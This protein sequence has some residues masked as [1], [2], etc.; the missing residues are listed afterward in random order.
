MA[1]TINGA[2]FFPED[3]VDSFES[4][5]N[6]LQNNQPILQPGVIGFIIFLLAFTF[7]YFLKSRSALNKYNASLMENFSNIEGLRLNWILSFQKLWILLFAFPLVIYFINYLYP[8]VSVFVTGGILLVS[9]VSLSVFFSSRLL[10]QS[11]ANLPPTER[12]IE[13]VKDPIE[14]SSNEKTQLH[15]LYEMLAQEKYYEDEHL[16]L[17]QL[18]G[19]LEM[20]SRE[21]TD[22]IKKSE[23]SNFYDLVNS[24]RVEQVKQALA[25]S[26]EQIIVIAY[27]SG[28]NSK[29]TFN[30]IFKQKT[31]FTPKEYRLSLK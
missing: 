21:L 27:Q 24:F 31:G 1:L 12:D 9:L 13:T 22:L 17:D 6:A 10:S 11:Y 5:V 26:N 7:F 15:Q 20:K 28:F 29:S 3:I 8:T 23:Y 16:S 25:N 2:L 14:L 4:S 30:K 19:H 18:A